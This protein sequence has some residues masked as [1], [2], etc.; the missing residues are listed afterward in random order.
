[1]RTPICLVTQLYQ[2]HCP[3]ATIPLDSIVQKS[4]VLPQL[5]FGTFRFQLLIAVDMVERQ[6]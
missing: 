5:H 2:S 4:C 6:L 3:F 1:M